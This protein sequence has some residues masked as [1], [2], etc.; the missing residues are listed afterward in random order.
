[1][2]LGQLSIQTFNDTA[3]EEFEWISNS[4]D[5]FIGNVITYPC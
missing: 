4:L 3:L 2:R 5:H 1:M